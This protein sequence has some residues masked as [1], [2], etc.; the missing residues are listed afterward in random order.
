MTKSSHDFL[1]YSPCPSN[2]NI[3]TTDGILSTV[4]G[5]EDVINSKFVLKNVLHVPKLSMNL[6]LIHKLTKDLNCTM[7]FSS[8][9][10]EF[11]DQGM[12]NM[13]G[14][15]RGR[16]GLYY[17][18]FDGQS[19]SRNNFSFSF[20]YESS[21]SNKN[22]IWLYHLRLGHPSFNVLKI[23]FPDFFYKGLIREYFIVMFV[24]LQNTNTLLF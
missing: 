6:V 24:S 20:L 9:H 22:K 4:A 23:L 8:T 17:L 16:N 2:K 12:G 13:I 1:S 7:T 21:L 18:E 14:L 3:S 11:Q 19:S 5:Q 10:C 15:A